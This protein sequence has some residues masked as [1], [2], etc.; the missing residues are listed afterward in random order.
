MYIKI[1]DGQVVKYPYSI[2]ELKRENPNVSFPENVESTGILEQFGV[3]QVVKVEAPSYTYKQNLIEETPNLING[4]W[5]QDWKVEDKPISEID[6]LHEQLRTQ[7]YRNESDPL[8][9]KAQRGEIT[10]EEWLNKVEEIKTR[11]P[12]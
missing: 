7:A 1:K 5:Y 12:K 3:F 4:Q 8:F 11:F 2:Y 10:I 6:E 9:F